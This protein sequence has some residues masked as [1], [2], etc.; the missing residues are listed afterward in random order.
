MA[1]GERHRHLVDGA[2]VLAR[3]DRHDG[4]RRQRDDEAEEQY[5]LAE[6]IKHRVP[7]DHLFASLVVNAPLDIAEL[8]DG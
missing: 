6:K 4:K 2:E 1:E 8:R 7:F 5:Q 3:S